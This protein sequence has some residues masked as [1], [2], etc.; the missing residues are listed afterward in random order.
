[1]L[2]SIWKAI[3]IVTVWIVLYYILQEFF[4]IQDLSGA[5]KAVGFVIALFLAAV[6]TNDI[7]K[8]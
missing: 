7:T 8:G 2:K 1:M 4:K 6:A 5:S 3:G